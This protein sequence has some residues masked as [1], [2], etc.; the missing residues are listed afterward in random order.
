MVPYGTLEVP[1][2]TILVHDEA[3]MVRYVKKIVHYG[4]AA[5]TLRCKSNTSWYITGTKRYSGYI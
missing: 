5:G 1:L 2:G 3:R 4:T